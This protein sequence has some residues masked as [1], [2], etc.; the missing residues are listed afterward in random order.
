MVHALRECW[1]VL[2]VGG[3][4]ID[5]RPFAGNWPLEV[6]IRPQ[7][8]GGEGLDVW[9]AG[10]LDDSQ[11]RPAD[12]AAN[13]AMA[14]AVRAGWFRSERATTFEYI[15]YWD[16]LAELEAYIADRWATVMRIPVQTRQEASRLLASAGPDARLRLRRGMLIGSYRRAA[17]P[18]AQ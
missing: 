10:T 14:Q 1:R 6:V 17:E 5:L 11:E 9:L 7:V 12:V 16:T 3:L 15:W 4:L 8:P 2:R 13:A 18:N